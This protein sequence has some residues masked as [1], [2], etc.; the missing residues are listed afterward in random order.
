MV[1]WQ[2]C[3]F[4]LPEIQEPIVD[5]GSFNMQKIIAEN[6]KKLGRFQGEEEAHEMIIEDC[7]MDLPELECDNCLD[8]AHISLLSKI[9]QKREELSTKNSKIEIN[10]SHLVVVKM[11]KSE[12]DYELC[13]VQN[14]FGDELDF[15]D[16]DVENVE[17]DCDSK[18]DISVVLNS[19]DIKKPKMPLSSSSKKLR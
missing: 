2:H 1:V 14:M 17:D 8:Q 11:E 16:E 18:H 4:E 19:S 12:P 10:K 7:D 13:Q 6:N 5:S 15:D 9:E 3:D